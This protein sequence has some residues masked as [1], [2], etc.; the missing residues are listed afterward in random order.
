MRQEKIIKYP[1]ATEKAVRLMEIENKLVFIVDKKA[2]KKEIKEVF[3]KEF[4]VKVIKVNTL[5]DTKGRKKAYISLSP[6]T[7]AIDVATQL[8]LM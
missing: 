2:K 4:K 6:E 8:G 5:F 7:P 1:L 3:E